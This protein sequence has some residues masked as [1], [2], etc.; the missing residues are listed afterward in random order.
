LRILHVTPSF[1]PAW[2]YGGVARCTYELCRTLVRQGADVTVWTTDVLDAAHRLRERPDP[3]EG[4]R[5]RHFPNVSN[6]LAYHLQLYLP[7]GLRAH[8]HAHLPHFDLVHLHAHRHLL[9]AIVAAAARQASVPY[10]LTGHGTVP[11]IERRLLVKRCVDALGARALLHGAARCIGVSAAEV[12]QLRAAGVAAASIRVI[13]NGVR[14]EEFAVLPARGEFRR[15]HGLGDAPLVLFVGKITPRKGVDVL[16]RALAQLPPDV[17]VVVAGNFMMPA[18][19][20]HRL[21]QQLGVEQRVHFVGFLAEAQKLAAYADADVVA[22]PSVHEI[23]GLVPFEALMCGTPV[24]VCDDSGCGEVVAQ[25]G[26]GLLVPYGQPAALAAAL[27]TLLLDPTRRSRC[28]AKGRRYVEHQLGWDHIA[29]RTLALYEE[30]IGEAKQAA[31]PGARVA[32]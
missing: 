15:A 16:I 6:R 11:A 32:S 9:N 25:A 14:L 5:V 3:V 13:P 21:A 8:A 2:A 7:R 23:F 20:L 1:Y 18:R 12:E 31:A 4:V 26:G 22:Y 17:Q 28:A 30:V 19:P 10:V 27:R 29:E 24:V